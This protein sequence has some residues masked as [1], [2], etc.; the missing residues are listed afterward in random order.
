MAL[1]EVVVISHHSHTH[2]DKHHGVEFVFEPNKK[3]QVP[4]AAAV[5]FFGVGLP[6]DAP[7]RQ[8]A[9]KRHGYTDNKKGEEYLKK[10]EVKIVDLVPAGSD[11]E[12]LKSEHEKLIEEIKEGSEKNLAA[13]EEDHRTEIARINKT[14]DDEVTA[15]KTRIAELEAPASGG[16]SHK[17]KA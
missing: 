9:W 7:A 4:L 10:F 3:V 12:E 6:A 8:A 17:A 11:V 16:K 13:L 15:L 1:Q 14:H 5:H 2:K